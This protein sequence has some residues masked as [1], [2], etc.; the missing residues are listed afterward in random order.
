M[1]APDARER[2]A[3]ATLAP[4]PAQLDL[5]GGAHEIGPQT[6]VMRLFAPA[7]QQLEGQTYMRTEWLP[8]Q[9]SPV[10]PTRTE[11]RWTSIG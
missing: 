8:E 6:E 4:L 2:R 3:S 9:V 1:S 10:A 7:P 5:D 11:E